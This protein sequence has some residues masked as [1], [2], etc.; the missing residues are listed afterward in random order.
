MNCKIIDFTIVF[1]INLG[2][3]P[4]RIENVIIFE[5]LG[6]ITTIAFKKIWYLLADAPDISIKVEIIDIHLT[7]N[8][9]LNYDS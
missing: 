3:R 5:T 1:A 6:F 2:F 4:L 7:C 9:V 8:L